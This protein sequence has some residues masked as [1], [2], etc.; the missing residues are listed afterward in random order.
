[1]REM[2]ATFAIPHGARAM[3]PSAASINLGAVGN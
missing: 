3:T 2:A 1:V